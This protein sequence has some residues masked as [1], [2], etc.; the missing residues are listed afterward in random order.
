[1]KQTNCDPTNRVGD[2]TAS[3]GEATLCMKQTKSDTATR[4]CEHQS[5]D[6]TGY[7]NN[8]STRMAT[9]QAPLTIIVEEYDQQNIR[10]HAFSQ[11]TNPSP[12]LNWLLKHNLLKAMEEGV[13]SDH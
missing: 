4:G 1:M 11:R 6:W 13:G 10:A 12:S 5:D 9:C 3:R 8:D 7:D 2:P